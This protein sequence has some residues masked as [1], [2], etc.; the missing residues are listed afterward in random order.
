MEFGA[1]LAGK[2]TWEHDLSSILAGFGPEYE[3]KGYEPLG[4][5]ALGPNLYL[6]HRRVSEL[7]PMP[8]G[9]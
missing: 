2:S 5:D 6:S 3:N 7:R 8:S 4:C 9:K 1:F